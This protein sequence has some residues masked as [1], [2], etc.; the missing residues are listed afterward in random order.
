V[1]R[2]DRVL[3]GRDRFR[4][5]SGQEAHHGE[6]ERG[7]RALGWTARQALRLLHVTGRLGHAGSRLGRAEVEQER[8]PQRCRR[9]LLKRPAQESH[10]LVRRAAGARASRGLRQRIQRPLLAHRAGRSAGQQ[11]GGHVLAASRVSRQRASG[12]QME[13]DLLGRRNRVLKRL[14]DDRVQEPRR[15]ARAQEL[16][17]DQCVHRVRRR[18]AVHARDLRDIR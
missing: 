12:G 4:Q 18:L 16:G 10:R 2:G 8:P 3:A 1:R 9:F 14:L 11:V 7:V 17:R 15:Q 5:V 13:L 6:A